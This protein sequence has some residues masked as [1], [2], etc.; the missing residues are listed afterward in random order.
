MPLENIQRSKVFHA[1]IKGWGQGSGLC[2]LWSLL[3]SLDNGQFI[4][5]RNISP[6][7]FSCLNLIYWSVPHTSSGWHCM[8][9][10]VA[11]SQMIH[12]IV[13]SYMVWQI[14]YRKDI[15]NLKYKDSN[16]FFW[17]KPTQWP[18]AFVLQVWVNSHITKSC[19]NRRTEIS[20]AISLKK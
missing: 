10:S 12:K 3:S 17:S 8:I 20:D 15:P 2:C 13:L 19:Q 18:S 6:C 7:S 9:I 11:Q 16:D 5:N 1:K 4:L 14:Q